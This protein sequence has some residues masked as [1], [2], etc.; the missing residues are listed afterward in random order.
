MAGLDGIERELDPGAPADYDLFEESHGEI[1]AGARARSTS[2]S[3]RS[4]PTTRSC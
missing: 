1:A 4:R 3:P 2:R